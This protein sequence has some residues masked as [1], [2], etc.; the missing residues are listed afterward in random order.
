M[1]HFFLF[2]LVYGTF[3]T[4]LKSCHLSLLLSLLTRFLVRFHYISSICIICQMGLFSA[5]LRG[6]VVVGEGNGWLKLTSGKRGSSQKIIPFS[7]DLFMAFPFLFTL[8]M[9]VTITSFTFRKLHATFF[10]VYWTKPPI[11]NNLPC[12][13]RPIS[14]RWLN[15]HKATNFLFLISLWN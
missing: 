13:G 3:N 6:L 2:H 7:V 12:K 10:A 15:H 4:G 11:S 5:A 8:P 1:L 9:A 14:L